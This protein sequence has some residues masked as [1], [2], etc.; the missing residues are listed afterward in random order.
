M[1][2][3]F[4]SLL[5][6][7]GLGPKLADMP[8]ILASLPP[9]KLRDTLIYMD[10]TGREFKTGPLTVGDVEWAIALYGSKPDTAGASG[11][12][13]PPDPTQPQ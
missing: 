7:V 11:P 4:R 8:A 6:A 9:G 2:H 3:P 12:C 5:R 13:V 10:D 1:K